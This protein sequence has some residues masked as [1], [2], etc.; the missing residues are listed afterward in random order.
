MRNAIIYDKAKLCNI[1]GLLSEYPVIDL[2]EKE[3]SVYIPAELKLQI[4]EIF[5]KLLVN[6]EKR[7]W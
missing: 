5:L 6:S 7:M 2:K 4:E 3:A 1:F